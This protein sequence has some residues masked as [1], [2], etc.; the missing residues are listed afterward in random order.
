M[1]TTM[2][3]PAVAIAAQENTQR[4]RRLLTGGVAAGPVFLGVTGVQLLTRD[5]FD[6]S[7]MPLSL[8]ALGDW[9]WIQITNFVL[10]GLLVLTGAAGLRR[11]L[12][13]QRA[14]HW[15]AGLIG[16]AG[17]G[18]IV[19]GVMISDPSMGWPV[20]APQGAPE[21]MS[22]H[23]IGHGVGA[24][25]TFGSLAVAAVIFAR[26]FAGLRRPGWVA[27][28]VLPVVA[29]GVVVAWPNLE[30]LSIAMAAGALVI[31]GWLSALTARIRS[32]TI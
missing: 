3:S 13:R 6:L 8:L 15:G 25:L 31:F 22:W 20:G 18:M 10:T 30:T 11:A 32:E 14:G 5:G 24:M 19:A 9:G 21:T 2:P 26:R 1:A 23:A 29:T 4:T 12:R 17:I 27:L 28:S 7:R 16:V